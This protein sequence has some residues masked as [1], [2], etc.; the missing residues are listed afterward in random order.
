MSKTIYQKVV[1]ENKQLSS[2]NTVLKGKLAKLEKENERLKTV[3]PQVPEIVKPNL[4]MTG[5]MFE[6][7]QERAEHFSLTGRRK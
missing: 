6:K 3:Q 2:S 4:Y 5:T 7:M 1:E